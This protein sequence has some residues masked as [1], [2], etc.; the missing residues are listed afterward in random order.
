MDKKKWIAVAAALL[1]CVGSATA[2]V[3]NYSSREAKKAEISEETPPVVAE[4]VEVG[5]KA[6]TVTTEK[7]NTSASRTTSTDVMDKKRKTAEK[8]GDRQER[9]EETS[10]T[11]TETDRVGTEQSVS[12]AKQ[13]TTEKITTEAITTEQ[14]A[15]QTSTE[16]LITEQQTTE[17][18]TTEQVLSESNTLEQTSTEQTVA[19]STE[20]QKIWHEP[21]T[22]Q[23]WVVDHEAWTETWEEPATEYHDVCNSCGAI[24]DGAGSDHLYN[25]WLQYLNGEIS[26]EQTCVGYST[27]VAFYKTITK[28]KEHP[29]EGHYETVIMKEGYWD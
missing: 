26:Y 1:V 14:P 29:E 9:K 19:E 28:T 8:T 13:S 25:S 27:D 15:N 23:V 2:F 5:E 21:V 24:V 6:D 17:Q 11:R 10:K 7:K 20:R 12:E 16:Q 3:G 4:R 22:E 18:T